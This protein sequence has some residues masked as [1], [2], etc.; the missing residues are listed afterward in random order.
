MDINEDNIQSYIEERLVQYTWSE[1]FFE[2]K[3]EVDKITEYKKENDLNS[4]EYNYT[5]IFMYYAIES[6][7]PISEFANILQISKN[8]EEGVSRFFNKADCNYEEK[9]DSHIYDKMS[10][11]FYEKE[12]ENIIFDEKKILYVYEIIKNVRQQNLLD[13]H[14]SRIDYFFAHIMNK[15]IAIGKKILENIVEN[16]T[17][18][19]EEHK[20]YP[21]MIRALINIFANES[22]STDVSEIYNIFKSNEK[23]YN[24]IKKNI[25]PLTLDTNPKYKVN[26]AVY[27]MVMQNEDNYFNIVMDIIKKLKKKLTIEQY[28]EL[29][30]DSCYA[31][32]MG[33]SENPIILNVEKIN[34]TNS[35]VDNIP[36]LIVL[37]SL[38]KTEQLQYII[39]ET[40][41]CEQYI[42][43]QKSNVDNFD[44]TPTINDNEYWMLKKFNFNDIEKFLQYHYLKNKYQPKEIKNIKT[45]I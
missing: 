7:C 8:Y 27:R 23:A 29:I 19:H 45:K 20:Q 39:G 9:E 44:L 38:I 10:Y 31:F 11:L 26:L 1:I 37:D 5:P 43:K 22:Y 33:I 2:L 18:W 41:I 32:E 21:N 24:E 28:N 40:D 25:I 13:F 15:D 6:K 17:M 30:E 42:K 36:Y 34:D 14:S 12:K 16:K 4:M 35:I 3:K